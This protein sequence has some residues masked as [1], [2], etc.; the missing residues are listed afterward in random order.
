LIKEERQEAVT[1]KRATTRA[2]RTKAWR[3]SECNERTFEPAGRASFAHMLI[4]PTSVPGKI[5]NIDAIASKIAGGIDY[6]Q[7]APNVSCDV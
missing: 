5:D 2:L 3:I 1:F 7:L 6:A 4:P